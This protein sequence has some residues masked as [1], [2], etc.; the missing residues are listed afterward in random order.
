MTEKTRAALIGGVALGVLSAIPPISFANVC[1]CMWVL[2]G[3]GLA[4]YLYM[5]RSPT[6][7][8]LADGAQLGAFAGIVGTV[9][10]HSIGI[11]LGLI[12][13]DSF[14]QML[15]KM[16][17]NF[18]PQQADIVRRAVEQSQAQSFVQKLPVIIGSMAL[19][20][21]V[22]IGFAA[23]GGLLAVRLFEK[24]Q[25]SVDNQPPPPPPDFG[26]TQP[27]ASGGYGSYGV[28]S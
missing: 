17:E 15:V 21:V 12:L 5:R 4:A 8:T 27:P 3:G 10:A 7:L 25:V 23:L 11:P 13:G 16:V 20:T 26:G 2:G 28:G 22:Y 9:V 24:R 19:N 6:A 14:N 18:N 1:C